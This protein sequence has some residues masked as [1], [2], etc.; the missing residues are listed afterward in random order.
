MKKIIA[1][2][3]ML[4]ILFACG[5]K[6]T[7]DTPPAPNPNPN[8][9]N[10]PVVVMSPQECEASWFRLLTDYTHKQSKI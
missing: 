4:P 5:D 7:P 8:P 6:N 2:L 1:L 10:P 3:F 9:P